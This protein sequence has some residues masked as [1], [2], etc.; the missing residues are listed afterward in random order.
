MGWFWTGALLGVVA[1][2]G[3]LAWLDRRARGRGHRLRASGQM[4][5]D[6]REAR[7]DARAVDARPL[8]VTQVSW[9]AQFR[10]RGGRDGGAERSPEDPA[11]PSAPHRPAG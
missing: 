2:L 11:P 4:G 1:L 7:R 5:A 3:V 9:M 8:G 6:L 10:G